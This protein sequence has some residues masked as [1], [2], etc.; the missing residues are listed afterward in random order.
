ME[1]KI[2]EIWLHL[3]LHLESKHNRL[4]DIT[5]SQRGIAQ[6]TIIADNKTKFI[7]KYIFVIFLLKQGS[8]SLQNSTDTALNAHHSRGS[9]THED[10]P[11]N[12]DNNTG[13]RSETSHPR[14]ER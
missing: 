9:Q 13:T 11:L 10:P 3:P 5:P 14:R 2:I 6:I 8:T 12:C 4:S 7:N 1:R